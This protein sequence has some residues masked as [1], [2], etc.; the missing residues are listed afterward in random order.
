MMERDV[1]LSR[2]EERPLLLRST[3][4]KF[5]TTGDA[6]APLMEPGGRGRPPVNRP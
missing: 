5:T 1:D 4:V 2:S 6:G 3:S